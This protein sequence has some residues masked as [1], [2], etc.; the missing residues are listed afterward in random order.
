MGE[1]LREKDTRVDEMIEDLYKV[2]P[3]ETKEI[4]NKL[5]LE[6]KEKDLIK[7]AQTVEERD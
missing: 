7:E 6:N 2:C 3:A 1:K 4:I 5:G